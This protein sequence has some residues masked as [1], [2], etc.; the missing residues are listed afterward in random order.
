ADAVGG[1]TGGG[2]IGT[3]P[4][5]SFQTSTQAGEEQGGDGRHEHQDGHEGQQQARLYDWE[6]GYSFLPHLAA[7]SLGIRSSHGST[8]P[9][10][11]VYSDSASSQQAYT[12]RGIQRGF[13]DMAASLFGYSYRQYM[14]LSY[15]TGQPQD[16]DDESSAFHYPSFY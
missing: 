16:D 13:D 10:T 1:I 7:L 4:S 6:Y 2:F 12:P 14:Q 5:F 3:Q 9:Q 11:G 15:R 8:N